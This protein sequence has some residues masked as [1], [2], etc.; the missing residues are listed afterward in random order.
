[1]KWLLAQS[2][3]CEAD[4]LI[5]KSAKV[6]EIEDPSF[7][8][9][10]IVALI[11]FAFAVL[12]TFM[13]HKIREAAFSVEQGHRNKLKEAG[14]PLEIRGREKVSFIAESLY[15]LG[16]VEVVFALWAIPLF[17]AIA[18]FFDWSSAIEYINTRDYTEALYIVVIMIVTSTRP[19]VHLAENIVHF[20]SKLFGDSISSWWFVILSIGPITGSFITEPAAMVICCVLLS[21][22]FYDYKP[23][24]RLA[25]ATLGLLFVNVSV[26]GVLT[27]FSAP[28]VLVVARCWDLSSWYMFKTFGVV[29][30]I[31]VLISNFLYWYFFR[32]EFK[33]L[34]LEK[35]QKPIER[36]ERDPI[37]FWIT[38]SHVLILGWIIFNAHYTAIVI[39]SLLLFLAFQ[40]ATHHYQDE[41]TLKR[42]FLVGAFIAG[43]IIH[44]GVQGWWVIAL[45]Q[46][47]EAFSLMFV[48]VVLSAF[49]ENAAVT[50]L[51]SLTPGLSESFKYAIISA[52]VTGGGLTVIA[53]AA[54][55]AGQSILEKHFDQGVAPLFLFLAAL[56]PTLI[57]FFLYYIPFLIWF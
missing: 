18:S 13:T 24:T 29:A 19:I 52:A 20:F 22:Q 16:E 27:N 39:G 35:Q 32:S 5:N 41:V 6:L 44:G 21:R 48:G 37:P 42:P 1:M 7:T 40:R 36:E 15:F 34:N 46:K 12:H 28:P 45:V 30:I 55:P 10:H 26:G 51:A 47:L 50:Y 4:S 54:N 53:H 38:F 8:T 2:G 43:L 25:Y 49:V 33:K 31:G 56:L 9:F 17:I 11:I 23:S 57:F 3:A 14:K